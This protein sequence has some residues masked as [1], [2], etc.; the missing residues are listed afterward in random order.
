MSIITLP[1][2][3]MIDPE[4]LS[5]DFSGMSWESDG[6]VLVLRQKSGSTLRFR[7]PTAVA[8]MEAIGNVDVAFDESENLE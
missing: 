3:S 7:G 4:Q 8:V 1:N 5:R 2:G 6:D